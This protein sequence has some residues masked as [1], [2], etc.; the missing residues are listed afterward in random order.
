[1]TDTKALNPSMVGRELPER[2]WSWKWRDAV[3]YALG[4]GARPAPAR[5][6]TPTV[7]RG[8]SISFTSVE[9]RRSCLRSPSS[10]G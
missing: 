7:T 9:G 5:W 6:P 8:T 10:R 4:V 1:V 3:V 2:I